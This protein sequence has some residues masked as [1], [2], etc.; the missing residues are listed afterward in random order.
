MLYVR[1]FLMSFL[2]AQ[3]DVHLKTPLN[4]IFIQFWKDKVKLY[5]KI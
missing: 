4:F 3:V 5:T 1:I 2:S